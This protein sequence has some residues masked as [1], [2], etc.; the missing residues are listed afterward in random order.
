MY[1]RNILGIYLHT[2]ENIILRLSQRKRIYADV[3]GHATIERVTSLLTS[4]LTHECIHFTH[5]NTL[6]VCTDLTNA[7][8][9]LVLW[10]QWEY[11]WLRV[12]ILATLRREPDVERRRA[13]RKLT[14]PLQTPVL[15]NHDAVRAEEEWGPDKEWT[16]IQL[17]TR[18]N[19]WFL[20]ACCIA[21]Q[22]NQY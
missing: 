22:D 16:Q 5:T 18:P 14:L 12:H 15:F 3:V 20:A 10:W 4:W 8:A 13:M 21:E 7:S 9:H 6:W 2:C 1:A 19:T 11:L 17:W